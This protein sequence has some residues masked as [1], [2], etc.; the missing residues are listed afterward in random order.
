LKE[1]RKCPNCKGRV[2]FPNER[3]RYT[4]SSDS[5]DETAESG[6]ER[7]SLLRPRENYRFIDT[8]TESHNSRALQDQ[9]Q[10]LQDPD[11]S[12]DEPPTTSQQENTLR[13]IKVTF[14]PAVSVLSSSSSSSSITTSTNTT[15]HNQIPQFP[16]AF[17]LPMAAKPCRSSPLKRGRKSILTSPPLPTDEQPQ[18]E[19]KLTTSTSSSETLIDFYDIS[20]QDPSEENSSLTNST[21][22]YHSCVGFDSEYPSL[23]RGSINGGSSSG[24]NNG[25]TGGGMYGS[26]NSLASDKS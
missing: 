26:F 19:E 1:S 22:S 8:L 11:Q 14:A 15:R 2:L 17:V 25:A 3:G 21:Q 23:D 18:N 4:Y 16:N 12:E 13:K 9:Y 6:D 7:T 10:Y 5:E 24:S 20:T